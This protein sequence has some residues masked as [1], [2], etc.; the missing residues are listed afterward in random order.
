M[1]HKLKLHKP[2]TK[3]TVYQKC[4]YYS[5]MKIYDKIPDLI[6]ELVIKK[7]MFF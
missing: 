4:V 7:E 1:R 5:R 2:S 3:L 6:A